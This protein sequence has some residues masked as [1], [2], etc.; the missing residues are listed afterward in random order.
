MSL[1]ERD[2]DGERIE[3]IRYD[4]FCVPAW[5]QHRHFNVGAERVYLFSF[6][7]RPLL[8]SLG[9]FRREEDSKTVNGT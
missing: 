7:H 5:K 8:E 3:W 6:S 4:T 1:K 2:V 9:M